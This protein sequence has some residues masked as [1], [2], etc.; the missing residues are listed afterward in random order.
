MF[1]TAVCAFSP[2]PSFSNVPLSHPTF[3]RGPRDLCTAVSGRQCYGDDIKDMGIASTAAD[4]CSA[5]KS[6]PGC[7]AWTWNADIDQ[8][9][10][11]KTNCS[12]TRFDSKYVSGF[13][14][15]PPTPPTEYVNNYDG[16]NPLGIVADPVR[17]NNY[18]LILGDWGKSGGPG[19]CQ[20]EVANKMNAFV[21]QQKAA[22][23]TLLFVAVVGDNFYWTGQSGNVWSSQWGDV[24]GVSDPASALH[25]VPF[26]AVLGNHDLGDSDL[27]ANCP[28]VQPRATVANQ[29][30]AAMQFNADKNPSRPSWTRPFHL[31]DYSYHYAIPAAGLEL[32]AL[33]QNAVDID[34]LGGDAGG[35]AKSFQVL[36]CMPCHRT[37]A[38]CGPART[39]RGQ[40]GSGVWV[41]R[42][43]AS[44]YRHLILIRW[45]C[46]YAAVGMLWRLISPACA[47]LGRVCSPCAQKQPEQRRSSLS[48]TTL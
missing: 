48:S 47:R 32:I 37:R 5:C 1:T 38:L 19:Q 44:I 10:W 13:A 14:S 40:F 34:G 42:L 23:K 25:G 12:D 21:E 16:D 46:R 36:P 26:L 2:E 7:A 35:H 27:Y 22:G 31:P 3:Y 15:S 11:V 17:S 9:C 30:Y 4:C 45:R 33:D 43:V 39:W 28:W 20:S 41:R 24:Y 18:F 8:H 6:T 29:S